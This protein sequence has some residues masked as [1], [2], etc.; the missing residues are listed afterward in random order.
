[1]GEVSA[2]HADLAEALGPDA[3]AHLL[4][5]SALTESFGTDW[6]RRW[7]A[8]PLAVVRPSGPDAVAGVLMA[9]ARHA[10]P[11][12]PQGGNTGLVGGS[13]PGADE[14]AVV[15]ALTRLRGHEPVDLASGQLTVGAG[16]TLA[17]VQHFARGVG[18]T[19]GVDL[20]ARDTATIGGTVATNAGG[21]RVCRFGDTRAQVTG[22]RAVLANG[23]V[24]SRLDGPP[25]D[26]AGYDLVQL[27]VGSEGTLGVVTDV[28][29]RLH[30]PDPPGVTTLV[31]VRSV[32][33][34][35]ELIPTAG[36]RLAELMTHDGLALTCDVT[37]LVPPLAREWPV[38][39]LLETSDLPSL[40]A[41]ADAVVDDRLLDYRERHPEA[42]ATLGVVHKYDVSI[43]LGRLDETLTDVAEAVAPHRLFVYG[44]LA[45]GNMHLGVV[46]PEPD[47]DR[48][49]ADVL[50]LVARV[51]G[52]I[53]SEHGVGRAKAGLLSLNRGPADLAAMR[54]IKAAL[55]PGAL[56]NPGVVLV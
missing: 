39:L 15:M 53:A 47:D 5:D 22:L 21:L 14:V 3:S 11:V 44:H 48:I 16:V 19:Y 9:C 32:A 8:R 31:G 34:A 43:P 30:A 18:R 42:L 20:G 29:V 49:D 26:G 40:P 46:G 28:R 7:S 52:S 24:I 56:L 27:L 36:L 37:G 25:K 23:S 51:G 55:D 35:V 17:D 45:E 54:A 6:T 12:V 50:T 2:L 13:V 10:V 41:D 4:T 33:E 38:Y 1:M